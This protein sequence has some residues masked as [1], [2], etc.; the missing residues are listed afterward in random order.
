MLPVLSRAD[1]KLGCQ[2]QNKKWIIDRSS[3]RMV[4]AVSISSN[5]LGVAILF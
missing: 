3:G 2:K 5:R 4:V 1:G